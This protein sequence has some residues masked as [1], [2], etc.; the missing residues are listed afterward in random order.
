MTKNKRRLY[1][2][3]RQ[4]VHGIGAIGASVL[5]VWMMPEPSMNGCPM[6]GPCHVWYMYITGFVFSVL[7]FV[8]GPRRQMYYVVVFMLIFFMGV[9]DSIS[10][11]EIYAYTSESFRGIFS[12]PM[13]Q[14]GMLGAA[15]CFLCCILVA[16]TGILRD[17][18]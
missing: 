1:L 15:V 13:F 18:R 12:N 8:I 10:T 2:G 4:I 3:I 7:C 9:V 11:G 6:I 14:G 17:S 5:L 16:R